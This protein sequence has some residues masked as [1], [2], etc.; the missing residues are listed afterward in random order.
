MT[1][2]SFWP[3]LHTLDSPNL[4]EGASMHTGEN[5]IGL[6]IRPRGRK[7]LDNKIFIRTAGNA[8]A[9]R[10]QHSV[11]PAIAVT[12][13]TQILDLRRDTRSLHVRM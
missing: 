5:R 10:D 12:M 9:A 8:A 7:H 2:S 6:G 11:G 13:R 4:A 1:G 3:E